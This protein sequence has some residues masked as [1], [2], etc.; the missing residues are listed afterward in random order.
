[1]HDLRFIDF[2]SSV[3]VNKCPDT[4]HGPTRD[5]AGGFDG[6]VGL[7]TVSGAVGTGLGSP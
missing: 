7:V 1:M 5:L 2:R 3:A 4:G 6:N